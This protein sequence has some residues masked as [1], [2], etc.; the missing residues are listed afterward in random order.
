MPLQKKA[1]KKGPKMLL[2]KTLSWPNPS[3][4]NSLSLKLLKASPFLRQL[5]SL[6]TSL[7]NAEGSMAQT[8]L[9]VSKTIIS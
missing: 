1:R 7:V 4:E 8:I 6:N 2:L 3:P 9:K 5:A